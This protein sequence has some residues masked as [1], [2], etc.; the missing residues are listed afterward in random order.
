M[1]LKGFLYSM[2]VA[3]IIVAMSSCSKIPKCVSMLHDNPV[4]V[5]R[6][7]VRQL[8]DK[9]ELSKEK[10]SLENSLSDLS[11]EAQE[12]IKEVLD[13]PVN[14]GLD[15]RDPLFLSVDENGSFRVVGTIY[16][17]D[18]FKDFLVAISKDAGFEVKE[19]D[20]LQV[21]ALDGAQLAFDN[22]CFLVSGADAD[23]RKVFEGV[24]TL[25]DDNDFNE[26]CA[27]EGDVQVLVYGEAFAD[28]LDVPQEAA[29][30]LKNMSMLYDL[31]FNQGEIVQTWQALFKDDAARKRFENYTAMAGDIKG[32]YAQHF[33]K[34]GFVV[35]GNIDGE[36]FYELLNK[37][38]AL[39]TVSQEF[40]IPVGDLTNVLK[41]IKGDCAFGINEMGRM[42]TGNGAFYL[43]MGSDKILQLIPD[44]LRGEMKQTGTNQYEVDADGMMASLGYKDG[45][46]YATFKVDSVMG[47]R[48]V[49][50]F[51]KAKNAL[52]ASDVKGKGT[53]LYAFLNFRMFDGEPMA[54]EIL[55]EFDYAEAYYDKDIKVTFR[56]VMKDKEKNSLVSFVKFLINMAPMAEPPIHHE[57]YGTRPVMV[58]DDYYKKDEQDFSWADDPEATKEAAKELEE[59]MN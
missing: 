28:A 21:V 55:K 27:R 22:D 17:A 37:L 5:M 30:R 40:D 15:L 14:L 34:N 23:L 56:I 58:N 33:S 42:G 53:G 16:D 46:F 41:S 25:A 24:G 6:I 47:S 50:P 11:K 51:V 36:K 19:K 9:G 26:M 48:A 29:D 4:A 45:A 38:G 57:S 13:D 35:F 43:S 59:L 12:K 18:D 44:E 10:E 1:K 8:A 39:K 2:F 20:G 54:K 32:D 3:T 52:A 7:D 49:P 31:V